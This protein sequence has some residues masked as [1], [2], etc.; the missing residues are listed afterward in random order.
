M[1]YRNP[2]YIYLEDIPAKKSS[3]P[4]NILVSELGYSKNIFGFQVKDNPTIE[5]Y[6]MLQKS[7]LGFSI[8]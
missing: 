6:M 4:M 1:D 2:N 7:N 3:Y 8:L 5:F